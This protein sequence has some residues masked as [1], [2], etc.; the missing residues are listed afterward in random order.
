[1]QLPFQTEEGIRY[2]PWPI[3]LPHDL[4]KQMLLAGFR[5]HLGYT[6]QRYWNVMN[7]EF[8]IERPPGDAIGLQ[9]WGDEGLI[10]EM[11]Q[12]MTFQWSSETSPW[13]RGSKRSR[14]LICLLPV[15][16][17]AIQNK[18]NLTLKSVVENIVA[19]LNWWSKNPVEGLYAQTTNVKGD[20]KYISQ[21]L[22]L[23]RKPDTDSLCFLCEGTK[24][25]RAPITDLTETALWRCLVPSCPWHHE[26]AVLKLSHFSLSMVGLDLM[27][28]FH[29]GMGRDVCASLLVIL[30]RTGHFPGNNVWALA[31]C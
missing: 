15:S 13:F 16:R 8:G 21:L 17:Y 2:E 7:Q 30:L 3:A 28:I 14:F 5:D 4:A 9:L 29:L 18:V 19:S 10:F 6:D 20:W 27:H 25:M 12:Y 22:C 1:M 23:K 31:V 24:G 11:E 26:P